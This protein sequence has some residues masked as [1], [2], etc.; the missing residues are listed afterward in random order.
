VIRRPNHTDLRQKLPVQNEAWEFQ[1]LGKTV[2]NRSPQN[3]E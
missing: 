1:M 2:R 3:A